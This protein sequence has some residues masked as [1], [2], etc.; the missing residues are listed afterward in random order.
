LPFHCL[1]CVAL[2]AHAATGAA[3]LVARTVG[4]AGH[5]A[6]LGPGSLPYSLGPL[7]ERMYL[8]WENTGDVPALGLVTSAQWV[9]AARLYLP[10]TTLEQALS[11]A[12]A[13]YAAAHASGY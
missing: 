12:A 11:A 1:V 2:A 7:L 9:A 3:Y 5:V 8:V 13:L 4:V 6:L 10:R